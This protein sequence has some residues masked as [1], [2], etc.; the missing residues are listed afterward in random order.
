MRVTLTFTQTFN[1]AF[2]AGTNELLIP[3]IALETNSAVNASGWHH[4]Y[5]GWKL[6]KA[7]LR[8]IGTYNAATFAATADTKNDGNYIALK[9][10]SGVDVVHTDDADNQLLAEGYGPFD[11]DGDIKI[12]GNG[13]DANTSVVVSVMAEY[14]GGPIAAR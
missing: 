8:T 5:N 9:D 2:I 14:E 13:G 4:S 12:S 1:A 3:V 11:D 7:T 10:G 6:K